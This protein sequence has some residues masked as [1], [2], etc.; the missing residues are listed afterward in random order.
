[1]KRDYKSHDAFYSSRA[2]K[3]LRYKALR[4]NGGRCE[5]C[6]RSAEDGVILEVDHIKPRSKHPELE[7]DLHN[8]QVLC[9]DCN[10]GKGNQDTYDWRDGPPPEDWNSL[11]HKLGRLA[12]KNP[13]WI[14]AI[15]IVGLLAVGADPVGIL[16]ILGIGAL[17]TWTSRK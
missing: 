16:L 13:V 14:A 3:N 6:G 15:V 1:M 17:L 12:A 7:L 9:H 5:A 4:L 2:W 11:K 10:Q 8:L